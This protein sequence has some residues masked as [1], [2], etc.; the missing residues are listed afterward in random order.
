VIIV[1]GMLVP[2]NLSLANIKRFIEDGVYEENPDSSLQSLTAAPFVQV[3]R[4]IANKNVT[5]DVYDSVTNFTDSRWQRVVAVFI[6]GQDWQFREW[7]NGQEKREL[8][9]RVRGYYIHYANTQIPTV[10]N[11]WNIK[12]LELQ[13]NKRH[14]D[15]NI[16]NNMWS[17]LEEFLR[18]E[19]FQG[20]DF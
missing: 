14:H 10:L 6:N 15:I 13:R 7:K 12:R 2:G 9:A 4:K 11:N 1:P 20:C 16:R 5:F 19:K 17:D 3:T 18:R 8:F